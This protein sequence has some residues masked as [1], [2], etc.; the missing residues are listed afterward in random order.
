MKKK[1]LTDSTTCAVYARKSTKQAGDGEDRSVVRQVQDAR[2][3]ATA[4]GWA[5][6]DAH[7]YVDDEVS[8]AETTKLR[9]KQRLLDRINDGPPFDVL[10]LRN[11]SRFSRRDGDEAFAE[12]KRISRA[13]VEIVFVED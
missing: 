6:L 12:L 1:K 13:G 9:G 11:E 3:F 5:V 10:L 7:V 2:D 4:R 8:G